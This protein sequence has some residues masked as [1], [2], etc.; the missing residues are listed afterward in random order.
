VTDAAW[1]KELATLLG[2]DLYGIAPVHRF[3]GA[4]AGFLQKAVP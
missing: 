4:P 1:V 3:D 2:A